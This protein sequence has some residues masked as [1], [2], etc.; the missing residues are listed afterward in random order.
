[1]MANVKQIMTYFS[2]PDRPVT[3]TEFK[4]FWSSLSDT[5]KDFYKEEVGKLLDN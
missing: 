4:L 5:E 1:M 2:A 3:P